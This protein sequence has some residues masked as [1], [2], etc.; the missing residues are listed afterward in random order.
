MSSKK[1]SI[2]TFKCE[3]L[4]IKI[5]AFLFFQYLY[6][7]NHPPKNAANKST[8]VHLR[9]NNKSTIEKKKVE[10]AYQGALVLVGVEVGELFLHVGLLLLPAPT[11][12]EQPRPAGINKKK[13]KT[14]LD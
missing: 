12:T 10:K 13:R 6:Q 4:K 2:S 14:G 11:P 3:I 9:F 8:G 1:N 5:Q 7:W